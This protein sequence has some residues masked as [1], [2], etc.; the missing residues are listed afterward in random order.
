VVLSYVD[1]EVFS[2]A[3]IDGTSVKNLVYGANH[4]NF[5]A[6]LALLSNCVRHRK[7]I[8]HATASLGLTELPDVHLLLV[9]AAEVMFGKGCLPG[10]SK[11]V[12]AV[13]CH[14][15]G[16]KQAAAK[17]ETLAEQPLPIPRWARINSLRGGDGNVNAAA[18]AVEDFLK[19]EG[20]TE[21]PPTSS[22]S[23]YSQQVRQLRPHKFIRD[24]HIK[25]LLAFAAGTVLSASK[26][27]QQGYLML[28]DKAR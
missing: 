4:P 12:L 15:E 22:S 11:P 20:F 18:K 23:Q 8:A 6:L 13:Q 7:L 1:P 27:Y 14:A 3:D 2:V 25:D 26:P 17:D 5:K 24:P 16:L 19:D 9:L 10:Q 28:Q 21:E